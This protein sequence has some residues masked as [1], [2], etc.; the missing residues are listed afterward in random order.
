MILAKTYP[1]PSAQYMETSC[2]AGINQNG[3]MRRLCPVPFRMIED[4]QQFQKWQWIDVLVKKANKDHRPESHN[5]YVDTISC[6]EVIE[7]KREWGYRREW[8]DKIPTFNN[9]DAIEVER[10]ND[11]LSLA[12]LRPKRLIRLEIKKAK[13]Q[14]WTAQ[15]ER[16]SRG[17]VML[18]FPVHGGIM[19]P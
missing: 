4:G 13:L 6:G 2:V 11:G 17:K 18:P 3:A 5:L 15:T 19:V 7:A 8:I 16:A 1:S 14:D 10:L 9:F 12:L